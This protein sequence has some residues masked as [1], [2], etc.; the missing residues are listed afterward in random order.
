M[1]KIAPFDVEQ[2]MDAYENTPEVLNVAETCCSSISI[3]ELVQF[4]ERRR[5]GDTA[6]RQDGAAFP[7]DLSTRLAYGAIRG[8]EK[9]RSHIADMYQD[10]PRSP[11]V[12]PP[13]QV[14]ITQGAISANHLVFYTLIG[15]RDHVICVFPT[16]QQ[17]YAVPE[18]LGA[19][20]SLWELQ[21]ADGWIPD[22]DRLK[23]L[24]KGNTKV[25][26]YLY[27]LAGMY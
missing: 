14:L 11:K 27:G 9:L 21:E 10:A 12:V 6:G 3:D 24:V 7:L 8:S 1:V 20:L 5:D 15:P 17:L 16:Y 19:E 25:S 26:S 23:A 13:E 18:S 4:D 2:W 22:V